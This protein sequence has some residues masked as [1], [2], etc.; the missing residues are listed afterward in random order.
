MIIDS[1]GNL[2][3]NLTIIKTET[4]NKDMH[5]I[6]YTDFKLFLNRNANRDIDYF[7]LLNNDSIELINNYYLKDFE[8]FQYQMI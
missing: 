2:P 7:N 3:E 8:I 4:L 6:G 1:S 5:D